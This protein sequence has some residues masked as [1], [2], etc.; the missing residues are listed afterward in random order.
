MA[1][2]NLKELLTEQARLHT[3]RSELTT[4]ALKAIKDE[5]GLIDS[6]LEAV[7]GLISEIVETGAA[8][9]ASMIP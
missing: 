7:T 2:K 5:L 3:K 1:G 6:D 4:N 9:I 8:N